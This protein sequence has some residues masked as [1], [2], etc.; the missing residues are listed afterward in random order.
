MKIEYIEIFHV[1]ALNPCL[2]S[3]PRLAHK[4]HQLIHALLNRL[5]LDV[6]VFG[7]CTA[8]RGHTQHHG[9][10]TLTEWDIRVSGARGQVAAEALLLE[11]AQPELDERVLDGDFPRGP[12]S[13]QDSFHAHA[14]AVGR[15]DQPLGLLGQHSQRVRVL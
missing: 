14:R 13:D 11:A 12:L 2:A 1:S 5:G 8:A 15:R 4:T 7:V 9:G 3:S 10:D 6:L